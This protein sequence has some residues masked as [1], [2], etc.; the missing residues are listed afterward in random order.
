MEWGK[1][2]KEKV[3][4]IIINLHDQTLRSIY[5][6]AGN[7]R[8]IK[9][10][11]NIETCLLYG[12]EVPDS[13]ARTYHVIASFKSIFCQFPELHSY[14]YIWWYTRAGHKP[15][16]EGLFFFGSTGQRQKTREKEKE[17]KKSLSSHPHYVNEVHDCS[18]GPSRVNYQ[19]LLSLIG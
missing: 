14:D 19:W 10:K 5:K 11:F 12:L 9:N 1:G 8:E 3:K 17:E 13:C 2:Q 16:K 18:V 15:Q 6:D 7:L 4:S